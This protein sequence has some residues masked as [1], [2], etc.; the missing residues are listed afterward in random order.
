MAEGHSPLAQF[1]IK[2]LVPF[3]IGGIDAAFTNASLSMAIAVAGITAF[4]ILGMSRAAIVPGRL[5]GLVETIYEF[6]ANMLRENAGDAG[7]KFFPFVFSL[8]M[9]ILFCNLIGLFGAFTVT[10]HI[11]VTF[12]LALMVFLLVTLVGFWRHGLHFLGIFLPQGTPALMLPL[13]IPIEI[14]SYLIRPVSLS[15]RL[16]G[17]MVAGHVMLTVIGGFVVSL[18]GYFFL[19][20]GMPLVFIVAIFALELLVALLQAYV[21]AI[22]T[23]IYLND[24]LHMSH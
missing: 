18:G 24:A 19:L 11:I 2:P 12:A 16:F 21:F 3:E 13:M 15:V 4:M 6:I 1:E 5:Q 14:V 10:S 23:C 9:F 7:R 22:L 17:N 8:F 20:G